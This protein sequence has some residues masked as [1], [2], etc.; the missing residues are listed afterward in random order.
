MDDP[1]TEA[2]LLTAEIRQS[3]RS[4]PHLRT[5]EAILQ[6]PRALEVIDSLVAMHEG[7]RA[8][9]IADQTRLTNAATSLLSEILKLREA[10]LTRQRLGLPSDGKTPADNFI[11][12]T[13]P[14][15][16]EC[17]HKLEG[18]LK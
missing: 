13:A 7:Y 11:D 16:W 1:I 9:V 6:Q 4:P 8:G 18:L 12:G 14:R 15:L 17:V 5:A 2:N 10:R 3:L